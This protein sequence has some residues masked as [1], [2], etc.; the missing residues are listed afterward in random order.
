MAKMAADPATQEWWKLT[1]PLQKP[2]ADRADNEWWASMPEVF[3]AD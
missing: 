1:V 3:H 2:L